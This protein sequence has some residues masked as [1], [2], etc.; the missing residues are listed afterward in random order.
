MS[1]HPVDN[2]RRWVIATQA[3]VV[4]VVAAVGLVALVVHP[5]WSAG[6]L[7]GLL[8]VVLAVA[9]P[10]A[11]VQAFRAARG[12]S[13]ERFDVHENGIAHTTKNGRR[14]WTWDQ[15]TE[16]RV[17]RDPGRSPRHGRNLRCAT[18][19]ADGGK[20]RFDGLTTNAPVLADA[21]TTSRPDAVAADDGMRGWKVLR[22]VLPVVAVGCGWYLVAAFL[23]LTDDEVEVEVQPGYV[24]MVPRFDDST[25]ALLAV[26]GLVCLV[27][28]VMSLA[29]LVVGFTRSRRR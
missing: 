29:Y 13:R 14:A 17:T 22:W 3:A 12:G 19:F 1:T 7:V 6:R 16:I 18:G 20:V 21:L 8:L 27:G 10:V 15:V 26:G 28:I 2:R 4:T 9:F 25:I 11:A 23:M 5:V 24:K